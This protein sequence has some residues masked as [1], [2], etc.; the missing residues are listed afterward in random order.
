MNF[1]CNKTW[2][3]I[4][5]FD[6]GSKPRKYFFKVKFENKKISIEKFAL[7]KLIASTMGAKSWTPLDTS[8]LHILNSSHAIEHLKLV[9]FFF[10]GFRFFPII[11]CAYSL[12]VKKYWPVIWCGI[13]PVLEKERKIWY[14]KR[15]RET[16]RYTSTLVRPSKCN[17]S[18][19]ITAMEKKP[20]SHLQVMTSLSKSYAVFNNLHVYFVF[21]LKI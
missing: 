6:H 15:K 17:K 14:I 11:V 2:H 20:Q 4:W 21:H 16:N 5:N 19:W 1:S 10:R 8:L 7:R 3:I 13:S 18:A 9:Y 12:F